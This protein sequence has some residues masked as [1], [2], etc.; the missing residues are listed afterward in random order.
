MYLQIIRLEGTCQIRL[1]NIT[2][3]DVKGNI[4]KIPDNAVATQSSNYSENIGNTLVSKLMIHNAIEPLIG[5][6]TMTAGTENGWWEIDLLKLVEVGKITIGNTNIGKVICMN[7]ER[8]LLFTEIREG[9]FSF[10]YFTDYTVH[11]PHTY[12]LSKKMSTGCLK[13]PNES[14]G[15]VY[16]YQSCTS[17]NPL[18]CPPLYNNQLPITIPNNSDT[19]YG[20][21]EKQKCKTIGT[22]DLINS[23]E[24]SECNGTQKI[25]QWEICPGFANCPEKTKFTETQDCKNGEL[26]WSTW[27]SC[28]D[29]KKTRIATCM[30]PING[31]KKCPNVPYT[32]TKNCLNIQLSEWSPWTP[33]DVHHKTIKTRTCK[34]GTDLLCKDI[35]EP[36]EL[37]KTCSD[38]KLTEWNKWSKCE[39]GTQKRT[40]ECLEP[41]NGGKDCPNE[42]L[43][44]EQI[45][46]NGQLTEWGEWTRCDGVESYR[47]RK[48]IEPIGKGDPC[49]STLL[50]ENKKC[51]KIWSEC[52]LN[53]EQYDQY[54]NKRNCTPMFTFFSSFCMLLILI[55]I[56]FFLN[57]Y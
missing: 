50:R 14:D 31:G 33:C 4:I 34:D 51:S 12:S 47:T 23:T 44:Q 9:Y 8:T 29:D 49:P 27:S 15:I 55:I 52:N 1:N 5:N 43:E 45:C 28:K 17:S 18:S 46:T 30:E 32:Q 26:V 16:T 19:K 6:T 38:G 7:S 40:R 2:L 20:V 35:T 56:L 54:N 25:R 3:F 53:F 11:L 13:T 42:S 24:W 22:Y 21:L 57:R 39:N 41:V 48:C 37:I 36:L 10:L